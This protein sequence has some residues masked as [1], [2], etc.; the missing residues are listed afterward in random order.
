MIRVILAT[1]VASLGVAKGPVTEKPPQFI[2]CGAN[3]LHVVYVCDA[4]ESVR[5]R[6]DASK[7]A[8]LKSIDALRPTQEFTVI[9]LAD[10]MAVAMSDGTVRALPENKRSAVGFIKDFRASGAANPRAGFKAAFAAGPHLVYFVTNGNFDGGAG[11]IEELRALN[12]R[13]RV[14][15]NTVT[16][17]PRDESAN[18]LLEQIAHENG[19]TFRDVSNDE[20]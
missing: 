17:Q 4:S 1:L 19:G 18:K 12:N 13:K 6:F 10:D 16:P 9:F 2:R 7:R 20:P 8:L 3:T 11:V 5:D 14:K 15:V